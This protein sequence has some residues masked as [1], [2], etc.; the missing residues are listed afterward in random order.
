MSGGSE[1]EQNLEALVE[2]LPPQAAERLSAA[3]AT[4]QLE[5]ID[6][7]SGAPTCRALGRWVYS[8][9]EPMREARRLVEHEIPSSTEICL[10]ENFGLG[11][12]VEAFLDRFPEAHAVILEP[13]I[14]WFRAAIEARDLTRLLRSRRVTLLIEAPP[15]VLPQLI[16]DARRV[17]VVRLRPLAEKNREYFEAISRELESLLSRRDVNANTLARFGKRW[18]RNLIRNLELLP[19]SRGVEELAAGFTDLPCLL[20]AAGPSLDIVLPHLRELRKRFLL[21][22]VDTSYRAALAAG[23]TPDLLVVVDPQFWN[24]RH[25]DGCR[26]D[27]TI[28]VSES[29]TYP[30][31][32][33][34]SLGPLFFCGSLFPL[35]Q[36]LE[37]KIGERGKL[38]AGGSVSTTAWDL[39]RTLGCTPIVCAGLDLGFPERKTHF[40]GGFFEERFHTLS[41]RTAPAESTAFHLLNDAQPYP[42]ENNSGGSTLTDH[43]LIIY[44]WWFENQRKIYPEAR[45]LSVAPHGIKIEGIEAVDLDELLAFPARRDEI[46]RRLRALLRTPA[47]TGP[48]ISIAAA[49]SE[50]I[51]RLSELRATASRGV[52]AVDELEGLLRS[53]K[54]PGSKLSELEELDARI[55]R[56]ETRDIA[57]F[58]MHS[59]AEAI[60]AG[61]SEND[62]TRARILGDSRTLYR[63]LAEASDYHIA[64]LNRAAAHLAS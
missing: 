9:R 10:F 17:H 48:S 42:V 26:L 51:D 57:G 45:T 23:V 19:G 55:S 30:A 53:G 8:R 56:E 37:A 33:H 16:E 29:S 15:A 52:A 22:C 46:E 12:H 47:A 62:D 1:L 54:E 38:G 35:G 59:S 14:R 18:V 43:R 60:L 3:E 24:S 61:D 7:P 58:L 13:D 4:E 63:R 20:L 11:Y 6:T 2:L 44:K 41:R 64:L 21:L 40:R 25:L 50:L 5:L 32:F 34:R 27:E 39:A 49:V 28:L 36:Y 31:V